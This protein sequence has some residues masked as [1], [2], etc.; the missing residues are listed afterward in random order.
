ML[1]MRKLKG[2]EEKVSIQRKLAF[3]I[4]KILSKNSYM[5]HLFLKK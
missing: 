3:S 5:A 4:V 1:N 2:M